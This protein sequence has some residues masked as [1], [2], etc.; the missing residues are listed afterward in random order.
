MMK[1]NKYDR[2]T[3]ICQ[4]QKIPLEEALSYFMKLTLCI[5]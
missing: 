1:M 4:Q 2:K 3:L 5:D